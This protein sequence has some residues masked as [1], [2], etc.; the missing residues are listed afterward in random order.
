MEGGG[1]IETP[2]LGKG[3]REA[4]THGKVA[5]GIGVEARLL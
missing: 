1:H 5:G 3:H 2:G 4:S